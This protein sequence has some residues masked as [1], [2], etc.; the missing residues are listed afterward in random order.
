MGGMGGMPFGFGGMGGMGGGGRGGRHSMR[1]RGEDTAHPL[2]VSL[3][4]L[5]N[6]KTSKLQLSKT[7]ICKKCKGAGGRQGAGASHCGACQGRGIKVTLRQIGPGMMQQSQSVCPD[8]R[9]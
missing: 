8:C 3:E 6:G 4:D 1:R 5:Y 2:K 7:V 9:G